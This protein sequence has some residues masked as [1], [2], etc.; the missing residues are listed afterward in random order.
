MAGS[1]L[2]TGSV[3]VTGVASLSSLEA[4]VYELT[5]RFTATVPTDVDAAHGVSTASWAALPATIGGD[6]TGVF[7]KATSEDLE[8]SLGTTSDEL[9]FTILEGEFAFIPTPAGT[10]KV[11]WTSGGGVEGEFDFV[12][13][14]AAS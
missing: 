8:V 13:F 9:D 10:V 11:K 4:T 6:V 3:R 14:G 12:L 5:S 2:V 1:A 7:I